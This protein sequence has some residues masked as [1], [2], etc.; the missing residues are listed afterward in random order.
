MILFF[1]IW[2]L[3]GLLSSIYLVYENL[4]N[5]LDFTVGDFCFILCI[6][7]LAI[8]P[9]YLV[10]DSLYSNYFKSFFEKF[11][12]KVLIKRFY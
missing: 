1:T 6:S 10:I 5:G 7:L 4:K 3:I 2:Y 12:S 8:V 11:T 9:F